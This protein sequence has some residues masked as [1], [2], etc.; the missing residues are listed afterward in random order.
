MVQD[1]SNWQICPLPGDRE[2][3]GRLVNLMPFD[4]PAHSAQL[5]EAVCQEGAAEIWQWL[6]LVQPQSARQ[7][8]SDY[9]QLV[10]TH[11]WRTLVIHS[12]KLDR[13][14]GV[15]SFMRLR[16]EV[17]SAEIG[18]V[19]YGPDLQRTPEATEA[20]YLASR[21]LFE[22]CGYRRF[23]WKCN[24]LNTPSR[25]AALRYGFTFEGQFRQ[26]MVVKGQN[27][28]TDWYSMLDRE[29]PICARAFEKWLLPENFEEA[30][31]QKKKLE[32]IRETLARAEAKK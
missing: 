10:A 12:K 23:E 2:L 16:P 21:H 1:L 5:F 9:T 17:G 24:H 18:A 29:W 32:H 19:T 14:L 31:Q 26:D 6:P 25:R 7:F 15:F 22:D 8:Q 20:F 13:L 30:G 11:G 3:P 27:R 28:D 4:A